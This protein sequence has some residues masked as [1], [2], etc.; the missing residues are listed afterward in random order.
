[1][2]E[3]RDETARALDPSE[4]AFHV[5]ATSVAAQFAAVLGAVSVRSVRRDHLDAELRELRIEAIAV[6]SPVADE[7]LREFLYESL[8][9]RFDDK[10]DFMALTTRNPDGDRKAMA[11]CH[12]HDLGRFAASSFANKS[13]PFFAPAWLPSMYAS[14][15]STLPRC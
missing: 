9:E 15:R 8:A 2:L 11:V 5:P 10:F 3:A 7:P 12:C 13:A 4:Q 6:V 1:V 14:L